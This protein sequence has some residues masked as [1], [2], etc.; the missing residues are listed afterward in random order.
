LLVPVPPWPVTR[1]PSLRP[2]FGHRP[3]D[4]AKEIAPMLF[5][6]DESPGSKTSGAHH[7]R[8]VLKLRN[9]VG[10]HSRP[11]GAF[12]RVAKAFASSVHVRY[13]GKEVD[14]KSILA[15]LSL[16]A[17]QDASITIEANGADAPAAID[18]LR[19]LIET[20]FGEPE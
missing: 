10:L 3:R 13:G 12:V 14:G 2:F 9:K 15:V 8:A 7:A 4:P 16:E 17:G 11:A 18:A 5:Q 6:N 1:S 20:K 19:H